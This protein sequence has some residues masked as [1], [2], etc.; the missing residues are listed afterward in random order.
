MSQDPNQP[1]K[2]GDKPPTR[3]NNP[4][5]FTPENKE[6]SS[7]M[8]KFKEIALPPPVPSVLVLGPVGSQ[9]SAIASGIAAATKQP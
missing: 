3:S 5:L 6:L 8:V 9:R 1:E 7:N 2:K 4:L